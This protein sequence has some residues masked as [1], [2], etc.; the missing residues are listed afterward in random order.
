MKR[1]MFAL[2]NTQEHDY[3]LICVIRVPAL[4]DCAN[5]GILCKQSGRAERVDKIKSCKS[6][7]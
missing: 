7:I 3:F 4:R 6:K 5:A 1:S 2:V